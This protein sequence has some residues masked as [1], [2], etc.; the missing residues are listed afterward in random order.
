MSKHSCC[1]NQHASESQAAILDCDHTGEEDQERTDIN[2]TVT[3]AEN[4]ELDSDS[5]DTDSNE[6]HHDDSLLA[7]SY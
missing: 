5:T 3:S 2:N 7:V 1:N 6:E 4:S